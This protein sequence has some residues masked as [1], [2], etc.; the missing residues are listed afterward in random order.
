MSPAVAT[1]REK[2][3]PTS[4]K[5]HA[6]VLAAPALLASFAFPAFCAPAIADDSHPAVA[7]ASMPELEQ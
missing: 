4:N 3:M 6:A 1:E 2:L 7:P 5:P